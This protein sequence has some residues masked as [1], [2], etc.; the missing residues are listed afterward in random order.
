MGGSE[1]KSKV[2]HSRSHKLLIPLYLFGDLSKKFEIEHQILVRNL[3]IAADDHMMACVRS[4]FWLSARFSGESEV[5]DKL[6][7]YLAK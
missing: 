3:Q 2:F 4:Q 1:R 5:A 6:K 7:H